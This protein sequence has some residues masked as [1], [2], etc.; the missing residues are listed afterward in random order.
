[1]FSFFRRVEYD[2]GL[3]I[4]GVY[5]VLCVFGQAYIGQTGRSIETRIQEDQRYNRL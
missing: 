1:M 4:P 3:K 2:M 5:S